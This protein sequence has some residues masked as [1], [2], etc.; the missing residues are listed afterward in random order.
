MDAL[1]AAGILAAD[2]EKILQELESQSD[3]S[4]SRV[5]PLP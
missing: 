4:V 1:E 3:G 2:E 5:R